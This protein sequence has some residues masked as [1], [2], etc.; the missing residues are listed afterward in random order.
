MSFSLN[1]SDIIAHVKNIVDSVRC[2]AC[3]K[4]DGGRTRFLCGHTSCD[5]CLT[6]SEECVLCVT[7]PTSL[8]KPKSD[9]PLSQRAQNAYNL[10]EVCQD[11]FHLDVYQR[12][13][14]GLR[15]SE[16][17]KAERELF[18]ECIQAPQKY[19]N[20][21]KSIVM[22]GDK[23]NLHSSFHFGEHISHSDSFKMNKCNNYVQQWLEKTENYPRKALADL[24]VNKSNSTRR[25]ILQ[26]KTVK[27]KSKQSNNS[28]VKAE[29]SNSKQRKRPFSTTS[30]SLIGQENSVPDLIIKKSKKSESKTF[31]HEL[32]NKTLECP[33]NEESGIVLDDEPI[34]IEDSQSQIIA[35]DKDKLAL[36]A[37]QAA[38]KEQSGVTAL[39]LETTQDL[40]L[41]PICI[42][43]KT[44]N[45]KHN[46]NVPFY[47]KGSL[48]D[49]SPHYPVDNKPDIERENVL[50]TIENQNFITTI[51]IMNTENIVNDK[52]SVNIQTNLNDEDR[53]PEIKEK[54][55]GNNNKFVPLPSENIV[56]EKNQE[57]QQS[58][59]IYNVCGD[60]NTTSK[61][62]GII[63]DDSD[64]DDSLFMGSYLQVEAEVH[65]SCEPLDY[66]IL[67]EISTSEL[68]HRS[69]N[70]M[71]CLSPDSNNSSEKENC[72]PNKGKKHK[73]VKKS[74]YF[75]K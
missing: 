58:P 52:K 61:R 47:K 62:G 25:K 57:S 49:C 51:N 33:D 44:S 39:T 43:S 67:N 56:T 34:L 45:K 37:V 54:S 71:R 28:H 19:C 20:K 36:L 65:R 24:N 73:N 11:T 63:I 64:S 17:L 30:F 53:M 15:V 66:G 27:S 13:S 69:R 41:P 21:R 75:K 70:K 46:K 68:P 26:Q 31:L 50:I 9:K 3:D 12:V 6:E 60:N 74:K 32:H 14:E 55:K 48:A 23:E 22:K 1:I 8:G 40:E 29:V 2:T 18:P 42:N 7:P 16:Q 10:L 72:D 5:D 59:C 38:E 4:A 35:E